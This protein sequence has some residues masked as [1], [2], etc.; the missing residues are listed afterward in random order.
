MARMSKVGSLQGRGSRA[1]RQ[2][3]RLGAITIASTAG[4]GIAAAGVTGVAGAAG[5]AGSSGGSSAGSSA[6]P[7]TLS[8]IQAK[9][10]AA[11]TQRVNSLNAA[12]AKVN[13]AKGLGSG[14]STLASY[15]GA[16]IAPLQQLNT[17][18]Q[19][20]TSITQARQDFSTIFSGYR[21]YLLVLPAARLA[22]DA[23]RISATVIPKLTADSSKAQAHE[24]AS[25]QGQLQP[26]IADLNTQITAAT[27]STNGLAG[28]VLGYT[29]AEWDANSALLST[30]KSDDQSAQAAVK[31]ARADL[32]QIAQILR[33]GTVAGASAGSSTSST[34]S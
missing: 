18:I 15:L 33:S 20:D 21:V 32:V 4:L 12:I 6:T 2:L 29:A 28:T 22:G 8:G 27:N 16:D 25:N 5:A 34:T 9:A 30:A 26:L 19:G 17:K 31:Q 23:D 3:V 11:I 13:A 14:Q 10:S 24:N 7:A 1:R